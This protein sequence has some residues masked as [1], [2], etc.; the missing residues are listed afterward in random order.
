MNTKTQ[1]QRIKDATAEF[2][3]IGYKQHSPESIVRAVLKAADAPPKPTWPTDQSTRK[4][5]ITGLGEPPGTEDFET[6]R[7]Y[8]RDAML[9]DPIIKAAIAYRDTWRGQSTVS[10]LGTAGVKLMGAVNEAGL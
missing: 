3:R 2:E 6:Q 5:S 4:S 8:L 1:E 7:R 9:A 10:T